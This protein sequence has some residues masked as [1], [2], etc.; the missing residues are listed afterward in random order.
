MFVDTDLAHEIV[1]QTQNTSTLNAINGQK[2]AFA[3]INQRRLAETLQDTL[4]TMVSKLEL[5]HQCLTIAYIYIERVVK[6]MQKNRF[7][8]SCATVKR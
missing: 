7:Y 4:L 5:P 8:I 2:S 3:Q 6:E 1:Y